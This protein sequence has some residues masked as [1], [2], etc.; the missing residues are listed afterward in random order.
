MQNKGLVPVAVVTGGS[1]G[2][3]SAVVEKLLQQ[4]YQV[5]NLD[6]QP[7]LA[8]VY[9]S[10]DVSKVSEV[11]QA[12]AR[13][14]AEYGRID[15]LVSNAGRHLSADI[16][17]TTETMLDELFA[18]NVKGA[19]AAVQAVLPAMK[20]QRDGVILLMAS[21]QALIGKR[22]S[23]V[24][25]L[26]K[27]A[28]ASMARTTALDYAA[29]HI[30]CNAVCPGTIDTPLYQQAITRYCAS[31]GRD[32]GEVH[33]EEAAEQ[34]LGRLGKPEEVAALVA[35][36]ASPEAAFITGSLQLIDGGYTAQ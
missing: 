5:I 6:I 34:P 28:L 3:G 31:S 24:Y 22:N 1:T 4:G 17:H 19:F 33:A 10:C 32:A 12:I 23:F 7:G 8:G 2:I 27:A 25:N 14:L 26:T 21:D 36:L 13:V 35:F 29:F 9:L 18:L 11:Q 15:V 20:Q 16:E 30:R